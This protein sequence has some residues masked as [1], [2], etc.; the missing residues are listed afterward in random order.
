MNAGKGFDKRLKDLRR[1]AESRLADPSGGIEPAADEKTRRLLHDLQVHQIEL[2]LQNEELREAQRK[3]E[4]S[5]DRYLDLYHGAP[6]G[7]VVTDAAAMILQAN[8]TFSQMLDR[9]LPAVR[10]K[11][12]ADMLHADDREIFFSRF[13]AFYNSPLNKRLE[14]RMRRW[15]GKVV[16]TQL[17]GRRINQRGAGA[18]AN[19]RS[20]P[21]F[22][23]I[24]DITRRKMDEQAIIR[25]KTQ[26]EQTFDAVPDLI[27]IINEKSDIVRVN[28]ALAGRLGVTPQAC[29]G[30]KCHQVL[31]E[32]RS[33]PADCPHQRFLATGRPNETEGFN[34][35]L[36]GYFITT[37]SPFNTDHT[38]AR[39]CI[40]ISRDITD[41]KRAEQ[42]LLK[43]RNLESI[44][45]LAGGI[46][47]DFNNILTALVGNIELAKL[48]HAPGDKVGGFLAG[49]LKAAFKARDL[50][51]RLLTFA[52]GGNPKI[53]PVT[54]ARLLE[55]A[56]QLNLSGSNVNYDLHLHDHLAPIVVDEIQIKS[57]LQNILD[58][59]REAMPWGGSLTVEARN[60]EVSPGNN[61]LIAPGRYVRIDIRDQGAGICPSHLD[62]IFDPYF[63]TKQMGSQKGM[64]LGLAIS[65]SI[66]R[67]HRG[68][69]SVRST[70]GEG[71]TVS[72]HLPAGS[73]PAPAAGGSPVLSAAKQGARHRLLLMEDEKT[74]WDVVRP[75]LQRMNCEA[76]FAA[77][78]SEAVALYERSL[79]NGPPYDALILDLTIRGGMGAKDVIREIHAI[80]PGAK[81]VVVSGYSTDAV[82]AEYQ[83]YGFVGALKK[84]F[85]IEELKSLV[86]ALLI[87]P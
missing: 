31:H 30:K 69:L 37:V 11:P 43:S 27:A 76:D 61:H 62:K 47:H 44:G 53:H 51:N 16:H 19:D 6:V 50:A 80:D 7:Y 15:D 67:K 3:L 39:W 59:A 23:T 86:Q 4:Q 29:V 82:F 74:I 20:D 71:T 52:K 48:Y 32:C 1:R 22:I 17:E 2:E 49:A 9:D 79:R 55:E 65:H 45:T 41:R 70:E 21:L 35:K 77:D 81:A 5:R 68:H 75:M 26:W 10:H 36:N 72:I 84:P 40:H 73:A 18:L 78:G 46:A 13:R 54:I 34:R 66:I 12:L 87:N 38:Q 85:Q 28:K 63:T 57:A 25:A 42:E 8:K 24:S 64:G 14:V 33:A 56:V 60:V 83:R 58:N